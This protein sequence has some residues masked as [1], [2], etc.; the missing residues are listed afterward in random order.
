[1]PDP[2]QDRQGV[3][4]ALV[5]NPDANLAFHGF[6][7]GIGV[8]DGAN[9]E[10]P[11]GKRSTHLSVGAG[12]NNL[13]VVTKLKVAALLGQPAQRPAVSHGSDRPEVVL[14]SALDLYRIKYD[15]LP[16]QPDGAPFQE[17]VGVEPVSPAAR[18]RHTY[19]Q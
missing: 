9:L 8:L 2:H 1:M 13:D 11:Q 14:G 17:A 12:R 16:I 7:E 18:Q 15:L 4:E 6:R 10:D 5:V 3:L 19:G